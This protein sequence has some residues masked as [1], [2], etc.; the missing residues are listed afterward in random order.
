LLGYMLVTA[1]LLQETAT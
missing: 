1:L